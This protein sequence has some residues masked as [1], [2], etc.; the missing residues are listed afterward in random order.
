MQITHSQK[1]EALELLAEKAEIEL[2][3][4]FVSVL[5]AF[6]NYSLSPEQEHYLG[7]FLPERFLSSNPSY[8]ET[9]IS[10][11]REGFIAEYRLS[12]LRKKAIMH[13]KPDHLIFSIILGEA[14]SS[15][16]EENRDDFAY[17]MG[18]E[19]LFS[20][21][22]TLK[23]GL[24]IHESFIFQD[25]KSSPE[26]RFS[27]SSRYINN[28]KGSKQMRPSDPFYS[29]ESF[30]FGVASAYGSMIVD[31]LACESLSC[32]IL[33]EDLFSEFEAYIEKTVMAIQEGDRADPYLEQRVFDITT[34]VNRKVIGAGFSQFSAYLNN[35]RTLCK[36]LRE[37]R[38]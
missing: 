33:E 9:S 13:S 38:G 35:V 3:N 12:S 30:Y 21:E 11:F 37:F 19:K 8:L 17:I 16:I 6:S 14:Q 31:A 25:M 5:D 10:A 23:K 26:A 1:K 32:A 15:L 24:C 2:G 7:A 18:E 29:S 28:M 27:I 20:K 22:Y 34:L 4:R 36:M